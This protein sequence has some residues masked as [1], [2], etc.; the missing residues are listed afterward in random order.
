MSDD[1]PAP[2]ASPG[3]PTPDAR[4]G[5]PEPATVA[6]LAEDLARSTA[7]QAVLD[8]LADNPD[9]QALEMLLQHLRHLAGPDTEEPPAA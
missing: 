3:L 4:H 1:L 7:E 8:A 5:E 9:G 6:E 2:H